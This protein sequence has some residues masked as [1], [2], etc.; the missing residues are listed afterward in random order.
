MP[1]SEWLLLMTQLPA[2]PS[3]LRVSVWRK[4]RE[5]G[6]ASLQNGVWIL[7]HNPENQMFMERLLAYI[8][9]KGASAQ[10]LLAQEL[11]Q[12]TH[13]DLITRFNADRD[14][15][16]EAFLEECAGFVALIEK[17]TQAS[18]FSFTELDEIEQYLAR[19]RKWIA[20]IQERD[21]FAAPKSKTAVAAMNECRLQLRDFTRQVYIEEEIDPP[22]DLYFFA[23]F[24]G[25]TDQDSSQDG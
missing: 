7:P 1:E 25:L 3:S 18:K 16:Y 4:L 12:T 21:F 24:P 17:E 13:A 22:P 10:I 20:K 19:L 23:E 8:K 2:K 5:A 15:E 14:Q 6:S 9:H 11:N